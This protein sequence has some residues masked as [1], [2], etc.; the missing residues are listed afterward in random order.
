ML[1]RPPDARLVA[2]PER[3]ASAEGARLR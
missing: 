2:A 1:G 3:R